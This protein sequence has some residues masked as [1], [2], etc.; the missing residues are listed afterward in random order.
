MYTHPTSTF[1]DDARFAERKRTRERSG[2]LGIGNAFVGY[3]VHGAESG[4]YCNTQVR[5]WELAQLAQGCSALHHSLHV[6]CTGC[7]CYSSPSPSSFSSTRMSP[8][9]CSAAACCDVCLPRYCAWR[10]APPGTKNAA[11]KGA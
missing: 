6:L 7:M 8:A 4:M 11:Q 5:A 2:T 1:A 10:P 9:D 3:R